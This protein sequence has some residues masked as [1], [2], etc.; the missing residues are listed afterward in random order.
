VIS[1]TIDD[2]EVEVFE[3]STIL[4]AAQK[5]G[6]DIPT[7]CYHK[8]LLPFGACRLCVVEV[9]Q[10][11]G[12]LIPSCSTPATNG[13]LVRTNTPE[14]RN[15]RRTLLELL[16]IH[17]PL[18]CPVCDKAGDCKLQDLVYEY[19]LTENRFQD[20]KFTNPI[21]HSSPLVERNTNR[22]VLCGMCARVCDEVVGVSAIS[23]V[24]RGFDTVIGTN[25]DWDQL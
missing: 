25:G 15:A 16:L 22:C 5:V 19:E 1:L 9:E 17:H 13:M 12:R 24:N 14:I 10:M 21:D 11:K 7:F 20:T 18:D 8:N 4:E 3:G 23:F 6:I 2:R